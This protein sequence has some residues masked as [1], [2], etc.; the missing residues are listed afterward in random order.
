MQRN[1]GET[2]L[3]WISCELTA[4]IDVIEDRVK[5]GLWTKSQAYLVNACDV[6][7]RHAAA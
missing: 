5:F 1:T 7:I 2:I 3:Q 4:G 6:V